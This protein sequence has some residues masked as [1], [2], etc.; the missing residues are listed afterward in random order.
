MGETLQQE[1]NTNRLFAV[2]LLVLKVRVMNH[3]GD[4]RNDWIVDCE[5]Q[6]QRLKGA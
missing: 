1:I 3:L 5:S 4:L 2:E 6:A